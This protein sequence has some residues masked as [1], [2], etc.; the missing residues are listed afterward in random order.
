MIWQDLVITIVSIIFSL[1]LVPQVYHVFK[2]K[3]CSIRLLT[4]VPNFIGLYCIS[5]V[6]YTLN[7]YFS[8]IVTAITGTFWLALFIQKLIYKEKEN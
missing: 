3:K 4:S 7:L 2:A 5:I 6:Y 8:T 1:A